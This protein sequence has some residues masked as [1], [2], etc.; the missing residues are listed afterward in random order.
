MKKV[1]VVV[2]Q[3]VHQAGSAVHVVEFREETFEGK[4]L[5]V[6]D[7]STIGINSKILIIKDGDEDLAVFRDWMYWKKLE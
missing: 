6:M 5:K 4:D 3:E 1:V 2:G 7:T